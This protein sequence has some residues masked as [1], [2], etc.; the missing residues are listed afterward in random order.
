VRAFARG[1]P[2]RGT[3]QTT[4]KESS[5]S[6]FIS[7]AL[8]QNGQAAPGGGGLTTLIFP[9]LLLVI[10]YFLLIRPQQK[11]AKEHRQLVANLGKGDEVVTSGGLLGRVME[12]GETFTTLEVSEGVQVKVQ[13]NAVASVMPKGT[14]KGKDVKKKD[15]DK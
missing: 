13:K 2:Q 9:V 15:E 3:E 12:V 8:A 4:F 14:M 1:T 6:F 11:R 5:M 10:F 7:D